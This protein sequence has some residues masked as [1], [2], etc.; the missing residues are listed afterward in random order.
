ME[1]KWIWLT[2]GEREDVY[3]EFKQTLPALAQATLIISADSEYAV[4]L[5]GEYVY[6]GQYADFPW[7]KIYDELDLT[8]YIKQDDANDLRIIVWHGGDEHNHT[9]YKNRPAVKF[10][11]ISDG[12]P[13][14][15]SGENTESRIACPW[16]S[17][18]K[19]KMTNL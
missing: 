4:Y 2:S 1:S 9:H 14:A 11:V 7:Y 15:C 6:S 10:S 13:V 8:S 18:L 3:G 19:R 16:V 17:G 12:K 5:N